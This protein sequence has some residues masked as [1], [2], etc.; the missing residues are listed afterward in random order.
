RRIFCKPH[1]A[2]SI[3][4]SLHVINS[5]FLPD[6]HCFV[7]IR[8]FRP[9]VKKTYKSS[10]ENIVCVC[11][12]TYCDDIESTDDI[13]SGIAVLYTS[14]RSGKRLE[15]S[16]ISISEGA[17]SSD[18]TITIDARETFQSIIGFGGAFT[19]AVGI[20]LRSLSEQ[21]QRNL[22]E[23]TDF[24]THEYSYAD[25]A[26]DFEMEKFALAKEDYQYKGGGALIG[27]VNGKYYRSYAAYLVKFFEEYAKNGISFLGNDT[28]K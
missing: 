24:S 19:D 21:A 20:N 12:S 18:V 10:E 6:R 27:E 4:G 22:L 28:A 1:W 7:F 14:S 17:S 23:S 16:T 3:F 13:P 25:T 2:S 11:N 8:L 5:C 15:K 9:V 26:N